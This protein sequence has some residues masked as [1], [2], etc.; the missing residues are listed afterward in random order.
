MFIP[1]GRGRIAKGPGNELQTGLIKSQVLL[2]NSKLSD[3]DN[4]PP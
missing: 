2:G 3:V 4:P 1:G